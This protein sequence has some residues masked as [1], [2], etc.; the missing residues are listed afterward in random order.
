M[1]PPTISIIT[2]TY[3]CGATLEKMLRSIVNQQYRPIEHLLIDGG[4]D[5]ET[6]A[7]ILSMQKRYPHI[8]LVVEQDKG[9]YDAMNKGIDLSVGTWLYFIGGD[10]ELIDDRVLSDLYERGYF[11]QKKVFYGNVLIKGNS[12]WAKDKTIYDGPFDLK[13][14]LTKNICH[15]AMFYPRQIIREIGYFNR[16]YHV[17]ADW[18][19]NLRCFAHQDFLYVDKT[20]AL[21]NSGGASSTKEEELMGKDFVI[22]VF[23]YFGINPADPS[24]F[25]SSSPFNHL[26]ER[27]V[28]RSIAETADEITMKLHPESELNG[29][30]PEQRALI[31]RLATRIKDLNELLIKKE[32]AFSEIKEGEKKKE[33]IINEQQHILTEKDRVIHDQQDNLLKNGVVIEE[34]QRFLT[35][36]ERVIY[37]QQENL[38]RNA[39]VI[40]EQ[41]KLNNQLEIHYETLDAEFKRVSQEMKTNIES[42]QQQVQVL[43]QTVASNEAR[44]LTIL[45]SMTWKTGKFLL[46]P[47]QFILRKFRKK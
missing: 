17:T 7:I 24:F 30:I 41:K 44:I 18:D 34:L 6:V 2:P 29:T 25:D 46:F 42:L 37:D 38:V 27:Y 4:S 14:L 43:Q 10:D 47:A 28:N 12:A 22:N 15:Q 9:L 35:E 20:I 3:N 1:N 26:M 32:I 16:K 45:H 5:D 19:F 31:L 8:R 40:E 21:F 39:T 13:K 11:S 33:T 36:K 23:G